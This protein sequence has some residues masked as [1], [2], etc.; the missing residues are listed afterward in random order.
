MELLLIG[1]K[2]DQL[3]SE[4]RVDSSKAKL[5]AQSK[6]MEFFEASAKTADQVSQSFLTLSRKLMSKRDSNTGK[7]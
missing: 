2:S 1:N 4:V 3:E 6:N 5:Y 7:G